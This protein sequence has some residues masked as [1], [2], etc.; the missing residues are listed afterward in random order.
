VK[1]AVVD[2]SGIPLIGT[3]VLG[4]HKSGSGWPPV[5]LERAEFEV[6]RLAAAETR[7]VTI[8]HDGRKLAEPAKPMNWATFR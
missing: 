1:V 8:L 4:W 7:T 2:P 5:P 6:V 3:V